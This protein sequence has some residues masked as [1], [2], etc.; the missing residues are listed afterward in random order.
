MLSKDAVRTRMDSESGL[1]FTEFSYQLLQGW[2]F[3]H[4]SRQ[5]GVRV[6]VRTGAPGTW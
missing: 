2:D 5:H 6:Q 1:S 4:L 3:V